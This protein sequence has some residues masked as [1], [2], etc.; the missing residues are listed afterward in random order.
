MAWDRGHHIKGEMVLYLSKLLNKTKDHEE[1]REKRG[2]VLALLI[3]SLGKR[4]IYSD[5]DKTGKKYLF[6]PLLY[7][8]INHEKNPKISDSKSKSF[9]HN[10]NL[11]IENYPYIFETLLQSAIDEVPWL[12]A[13]AKGPKSKLQ[14]LALETIRIMGIR[15]EVLYAFLKETAQNLMLTPLTDEDFDIGSP[16]YDQSLTINQLIENFLALELEMSSSSNLS[17]DFIKQIRSKL[18]SEIFPILALPQRLSDVDEYTRLNV[19]SV[20][21]DI[22][23]EPKKALELFTQVELRGYEFDDSVVC[24][25]EN[26]YKKYKKTISAEDP[27]L[28]KKLIQFT[29][30][31]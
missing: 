6:Y 12:I 19:V 10:P 17:P 28:T 8:F 4:A 31:P 5:P 9:F 2:H 24:A 20:I 16:K 30:K 15:N 25:V 11:Q 1:F 26:F 14:E 27:M 13:L 18:R 3:P 23:P 22:D 29:K 7:I 21:Y